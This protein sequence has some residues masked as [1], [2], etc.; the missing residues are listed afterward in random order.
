MSSRQQMKKEVPEK[1]R[2]KLL[3]EFFEVDWNK[4]SVRLLNYTK[5]K[6]QSKAWNDP[7][8]LAGNEVGDIVQ[9]AIAKTL[10]FLQTGNTGSGYRLWDGTKELLYH[11]MDV[12]DSEL[13]NLVES[14]AHTSSLH[15]K[16]EAEW[17]SQFRTKGTPDQALLTKEYLETHGNL[18]KKITEVCED[19]ED[20]SMVLMAIEDMKEDQKLSNQ[21]IGKQCDL[22]ADKVRNALRRIRRKAEPIRKNLFEEKEKSDE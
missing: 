1:L 7:E 15:F 13:N 9:S 10:A 19:N 12:I 8:G 3:E 22:S 21:T 5:K 6:S 16:D 2:Q 18:F 14:K 17:D 20:E 4:V 11:L